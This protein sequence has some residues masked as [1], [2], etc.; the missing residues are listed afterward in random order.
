MVDFGAPLIRNDHLGDLEENWLYVKQIKPVNVWLHEGVG[1][2]VPLF[3]NIDN[4]KFCFLK[5]LSE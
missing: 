3:A 2:A 4:F 5:I 1:L